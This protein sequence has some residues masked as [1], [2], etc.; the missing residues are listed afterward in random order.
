MKHKL[1]L[2]VIAN[3]LTKEKL[4]LA[5][6]GIGITEIRELK[7][8]GYNVKS[9]A[10][11]K[12]NHYWIKIMD[13]DNHLIISP[14]KSVSSIIKFV[15]LSDIHAGCYTFDDKGLDW[16]LNEAKDRGFKH[17]HNS[18]DVVDG[19][20]VYRGHVNYLKYVR[21]EDQV[22][23]IVDIIGKYQDTFDWI[24][25]DGNHDMS[26]INKGA[27]SPNKLISKA[28]KNYTYLPGAGADKVVRGD[29]VIDGVMKRMVHPWSNSGRGTY[30]KSYPGQVYLRNLMDNNVQFEIGNKKYHL[31]LLQYGH[32]HFD[33]MYQTFGVIVTHPMSFQKPND[34]T[35]G[36]GIVGPRGCRLTELVIHD[37]DILEHKSESL[38]VPENL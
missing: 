15:E 14:R 7:D 2:E 9:E 16:C 30:A 1:D 24:A 12:T 4:S 36:K 3:K 26:W 5:K 6:L 17:I 25:I 13:N 8:R 11:N 31:S 33:M 21:E 37:G 18:G 27:P 28:V 10:Y 22:K 23:C 29:L 20:D 32:L 19:K 38:N 34:F 35:E